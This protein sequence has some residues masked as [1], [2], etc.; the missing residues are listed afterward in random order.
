ME[1]EPDFHPL[2]QQAFL[3]PSL[4]T[5]LSHLLLVEAVDK[6]GLCS[7][8]DKLMGPHG[9]HDKPHRIFSSEI[10]N[11]AGWQ[12]VI[13]QASISLSKGQSPPSVSPDAFFFFSSWRA[14][15]WHIRGIFFLDH[16]CHRV[17]DKCVR[18]Q[19]PLYYLVPCTPSLCPVNANCPLPTNV[20]SMCLYFAF[21]FPILEISLLCFLSPPSG[22]YPNFII[23]YLDDNV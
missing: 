1:Q 2:L 17:W 16:S 11:W 21:F 15:L 12:V 22:F 20:K 10:S 6:K 3:G 23:F 7:N 9:R 18:P 13:S 8:S 5:T 4:M 14:E 19:H